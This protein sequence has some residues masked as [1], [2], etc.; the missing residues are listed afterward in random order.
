MHRPAF[1]IAFAVILLI[2]SQV[3]SQNSERIVLLDNFGEFDLGERIFIF[4][5]IASIS[6][7]SFL[8]LKIINPNDDLC[9][10]QQLTPLSNGMF[11]TESIPLE[12]RMCGVSGEYE[13]KVFYGDYSSSAKFVVTTKS[14]DKKTNP[15]YFTAAE[16]LLADKIQSTGE[17]TGASTL[18]YSEQFSSITS[19][20]APSISALEQLYVDLWDDFFIEEELFEVDIQ[21]R[22]AITSALDATAELVES[23][24]ITFDLA[25][26]LDRETYAA[27]FYT[28]IG[29]NK[30]AIAK[31]NDVFVLI[32]NADPIKIVQERTKTFEE[33][34]GYTK[35]DP[36]GK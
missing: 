32:S 26:N 4:G 34:D 30:N 2:P 24:K 15:E 12:G 29:D 16:N 8:I 35:F 3:F 33:L 17:I 19:Q 21:F 23:G 22:P 5:S 25:N 11:I 20:P 36:S 10:I 28:H 7:D 1:I 27:I 6:P 31:L 14:F 13:V 9:Q 18:V